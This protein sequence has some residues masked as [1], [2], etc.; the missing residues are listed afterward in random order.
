MFSPCV[1]LSPSG[2]FNDI[3]C[4][5]G[6]A[7]VAVAKCPLGCGWG[8]WMFCRVVLLIPTGLFSFLF[9][10]YSTVDGVVL[11]VD[12][13]VVQQHFR[14]GLDAG[15]DYLLQGFCSYHV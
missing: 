7:D 9:C 15:M 13:I 3:W 5:L 14:V 10:K 8:S 12:V 11:L 2:S 4:G 1:A 6:L